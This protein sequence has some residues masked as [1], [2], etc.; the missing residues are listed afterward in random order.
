M[1]R[2]ASHTHPKQRVAFAG[3]VALV[4]FLVPLLPALLVAPEWQ[5]AL[6]ATL[7]VSAF[8]FELLSR[9]QPEW[10]YGLAFA[11]IPALVVGVGAGVVVGVDPSGS[12][13]EGVFYFFVVFV[14]AF[15]LG[16][17]GASIA[18]LVA[19]P[20]NPENRLWAPRRLRAWH[21]GAAVA[22]AEIVAV[23]ALTGA[24]S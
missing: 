22:V 6:A 4:T 14:P 7:V 5:L 18:S 16:M 9:P 23:A 21:V 24:M 8:V 20:L 11:L 2:T 17:L 19:R 15:L 3:I 12:R 10:G 1:Y 13:W